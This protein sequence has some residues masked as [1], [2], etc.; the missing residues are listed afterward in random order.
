MIRK[1]ERFLSKVYAF[2]DVVVIQLAFFLSW[3]IR[4]MILSDGI[5]TISFI[6]YFRWNLFYTISVV[7]ISALLGLYSSKRRRSYTFEIYRVCQAHLVSVV[8]FMSLLF[9][10][11]TIDI[12]RIYLMI[13]ILANISLSVAYRF[14]VKYVLKI[15]RKRGYNKKFML[16]LGAGTLG[17]KFY[18]NIRKHP[19]LGYEIIGFLDD[20]QEGFYRE[21]NMEIPILD[22]IDRLDVVLKQHLVDEVVVALPLYA[23]EKFQNIIFSCEKAGIK[24]LIIP[25]Y[26]HFLPAKP[27]IDSVGEM[28][29]I[30]IRDVP[31]DEMQLRFFKRLFDIVFSLIVLLLLSPLLILIAF[32]VKLSSPGPIIFKQERVGLNRRSFNI[33]KFRTMRVMNN[34]ISNNQWTTA[35]DSRVTIFGSFLRKSS[36][37]ELPQFLNVLKGDMSVVG[38]RPERPFFVERFREEIPQYMIKHHVRPGITGWAQVNGLRGDT[39][40]ED[41]IKYDVFYVENWTFIFDI[42]IILKTFLTGFINKNAY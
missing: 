39:S 1:N 15:L 32:L 7:T 5:E 33:Y 16:V 11:R 13:F 41:R 2:T 24:V 35:N 22:K 12:S 34:D 42:K 9:I 17:K 19:E 20:Y 8:V 26:Y 23:H 38:P 14:V 37:D 4:F 28:P 40:I 30:N 21:D 27:S 6:D 10:L 31:L 36:L 3:I 18:N 29:L 25:D